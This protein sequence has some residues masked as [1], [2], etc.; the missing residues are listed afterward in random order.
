MNVMDQPKKV[1]AI[2][3]IEAEYY[4]DEATPETVRYCVEQTLE[5]AGFDVEVVNLTKGET[6]CEKPSATA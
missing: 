5:D 3:R 6:K 4:D 1:T 2:L